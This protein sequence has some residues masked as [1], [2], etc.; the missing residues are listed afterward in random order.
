MSKSV[1]FRRRLAVALITTLVAGVSYAIYALKVNEIRVT[2]LRTLDPKQVIE[3]SGLH[4]GERILWIRLSAVAGRVEKIPSVDSVTAERSFP[5]TVVLRVQERDPLV[6]LQSGTGGLSAD[7]DGRMF[8]SP[9]AGLL[10]VL[11]GWRAPPRPGASL[12]RSAR[13]VLEAFTGFPDALRERTG[14]I[15]LGPPLTLRL[16]DGGEVRFGMHTDLVAKARAADAVLAAEHGRELE[17]VDVRAPSVPVS[18]ERAPPT[19]VPTARPTARPA[20]AS[21]QVTPTPAPQVTSPTPAA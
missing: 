6:R 15:V 5:Q 16:K 4:G 21:P 13:S 10:P 17:Y 11:E 20:A 14:V 1:I 7:A 12:D 3:A 19:P 9:E 18:R 2:G 8:I